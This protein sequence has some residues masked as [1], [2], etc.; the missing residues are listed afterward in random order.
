MSS[1]A[2]AAHMDDPL[3]D[4]KFLLYHYSLRAL[5]NQ[6]DALRAME[7]IMRKVSDK[8]KCGFL[9][10]L[11]SIAL[12]EFLLFRA[13]TGTLHRRAEFPSY[14]WAGWRGGMN[15]LQQGYIFSGR[16]RWLKRCTWIVWYER[17]PSGTTTLVC[18][19]ALSESK[20]AT[21]ENLPGYRLIASVH[22]HGIETLRTA[23]TE[24]II[25]TSNVLSYPLLQFWTVSLFYRLDNLDVF[26]ARCSLV[27]VYDQ[28]VG[29][30]SLEGLE[31]TNYFNHQEPFEVI[32]ISIHEAHMRS[33]IN[34]MLLGW[35]Q[36][37]AERRGVGILGCDTCG[38][39]FPP[40]PLWKEII[41]G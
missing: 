17:S 13:Q 22:P 20:F 29:V 3:E 6:G 1:L 8:V 34:V 14:S 12:D 25:L 35:S 37:I 5:T 40:G 36:G 32:L 33:L 27:D 4:Y 15:I 10:G 41:L 24:D 2:N 30:V 7:G 11:P 28:E 39:G 26:A 9:Q 31:E 38:S 18:D 16:G 19:N 23:P 21:I